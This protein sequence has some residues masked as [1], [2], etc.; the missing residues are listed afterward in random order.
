MAQ[1]P[2][3]FS[4]L[5]TGG[6]YDAET[7]C[8]RANDSSRLGLVNSPVNLES[9]PIIMHAHSHHP[10]NLRPS[11]HWSDRPQSNAYTLQNL[12]DHRGLEG[13]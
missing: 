2:K 6:H 9:V 7:A 1:Q 10:H 12:H 4:V 3:P 8:Q 5:R 13:P 11:S